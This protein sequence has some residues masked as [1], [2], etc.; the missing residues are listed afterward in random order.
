MPQLTLAAR[1]STTASEALTLAE[2]VGMGA[3]APLPLLWTAVWTTADAPKN[4]A[5][6]TRYTTISKTVPVWPEPRSTVK[7]SGVAVAVV[8]EANA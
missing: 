6:L 2:K 5:F 4:G 1:T 3:L 7:A 8:F